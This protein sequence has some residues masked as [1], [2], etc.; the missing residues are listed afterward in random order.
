MTDR[1]TFPVGVNIFVIRDNK[2]LLGKRKNA[3]GEGSWGLPG[4]HL[5]IMEK[6]KVAAARELQEETGLIAKRFVFNNLVNQTQRP[7]NKHYLQIGM[8]AEGVE[9]EPQLMEPDKCYEW[10]WFDLKDL[11]DPVFIGHIKQI[12]LYIKNTARFG[13]AS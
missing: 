11:P 6:I 12:E 4:G 7:D 5:E 9:G 13:E 8:V 10:Q 3:F 2:V 1:P